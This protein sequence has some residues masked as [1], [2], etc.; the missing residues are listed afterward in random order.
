MV[1]F[2][3]ADPWGALVALSTTFGHAVIAALRVIPLRRRRHVL[4]DRVRSCGRW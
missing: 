4:H 1:A 3:K 2:V